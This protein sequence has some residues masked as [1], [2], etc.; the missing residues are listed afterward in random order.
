M[1]SA[2]SGKLKTHQTLPHG[3]KKYSA[4]LPQHAKRDSPRDVR[5]VRRVRSLQKPHG[6]LAPLRTPPTKHLQPK[7]GWEV[8]VTVQWTGPHV[9][10]RLQGELHSDVDKLFRQVS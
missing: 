9:K 3:M 10:V 4:T 2:L 6:T 1:R 8:P 7:M 5:R